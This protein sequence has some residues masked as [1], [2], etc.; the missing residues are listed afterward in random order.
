MLQIC[1]EEDICLYCLN[2][3]WEG[4]FEWPKTWDHSLRIAENSWVLGLESL[5]KFFE[6]R[7][8]RNKIPEKKML[9]T[10]NKLQPINLPDT[11]GTS[12]RTGFY[13]QIKQK[14]CLLAA[15]TQDGFGAHRS[16]KYPVYNEIYCIFNVVGPY[17]C[18]RSWAF[19]SDSWHRGFN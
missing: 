14:I 18:Q 3:R 6:G 19:Y 17:F 2:A 11:T 8:S 12:N 1:L 5:K 10:E 16:K 7:V 13:F 4:E 9:S 15:N